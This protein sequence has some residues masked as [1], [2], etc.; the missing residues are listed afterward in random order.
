V[1]ELNASLARELFDYDEETGL[2][3][4]KISPASNVFAGTEAGSVSIRGY[5]RLVY[6]QRWYLVHRVVW[7]VATGAWP[8]NGLD[9][10]N[11]N[12]SDNRLCNLREAS[13][14]SNAQNC[15]IHREGHL[16]GTTFNK[17]AGRWY[18]QVRDG[19][20]KVY[21]GAYDTNEEAHEAYKK[22]LTQRRQK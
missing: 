2:L 4:W 15:K 22:Y 21:L 12:T 11:G 7:L 1:V 20:K 8:K 13:H 10:L 17:K 18:A 16:P 19:K 6:K 5:K 3:R 14:R 9:H